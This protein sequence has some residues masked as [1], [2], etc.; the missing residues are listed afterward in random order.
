MILKRF[1]TDSLD[2]HPLWAGMSADLP[3]ERAAWIGLE[4]VDT[5]RPLFLRLKR[6]LE[7]PGGK[8]RFYLSADQRYQLWIN[9]KF[10]ALGPDRSDLNHWSVAGYELESEGEPLEL[11]LRLWWLP[12][13]L[14]PL[15]QCTHRPGFVLKG[16]GLLDA[17]LT[18]G[19]ADW[20][21]EDV[22][23]AVSCVKPDLCGFHVV[24]PSF[25]I[26]MTAWDCQSR[27][28]PMAVLRPPEE[29]ERYGAR[30]LGWRMHPSRLPEQRSERFQPCTVR[31]L[32]VPVRE[33]PWMLSD[34][35]DPSMAEVQAF[36]RGNSGAFV[37]PPER[38]IECL[39]DLET[40]VC[41]YPEL[42]VSGGLGAEVSLEW[43]E[44]LFE[45]VSGRAVQPETSKGQR[46]RVE[47]KV[48]HGFGDRWR[49]SG[50][51]NRDLPAFWWR[52]G[53]YLRLILR[54][55]SE[56]LRLEAFSVRRT[57]FPFRAEGEFSCDRPELND[58]WPL[59]VAGLEHCAHEQWVDC[60]YYEQLS[61]VGD[62]TAELSF[63]CLTRDDA[64]TRRS[65]E[66]FDWSRH[67]NGWVAQRY[68]SAIRQDSFTYS[69]LYP[70]LVRDYAYWRRDEGFVAALLP[71]IRAMMQECL[72][73]QGADGLVH[74][75]PGWAFV[76]W[77]PEWDRGCPPG[78]EAGDSSLVNLHVSRALEA[79]ADLEENGGERD[80]APWIRQKRQ[81]LNQ[82]ICA[83]Y[84]SERDQA[85]ADDG[86][87]QTFSE[88]AQVWGIL[89]GVLAPDQE[90][91]C[92]RTWLTKRLPMAPMS[93]Y[94]SHYGFEALYRLGESRA[95]LDR[96]QF[97]SGLKAQGL[98]TT[99]ERPEPSRSDCHGWGAHPLFHCFASLAG[100]R[101]ASP[102]FQ[103][104]RIAPLAGALR[105]IS[106]TLP[107]PEGTLRLTLQTENGEGSVQIFLPGDLSGE[108]LYGDQARKLTPGINA[109][110]VSIPDGFAPV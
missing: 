31:A 41:G 35:G 2:R 12:E 9:G 7:L 51:N 29:H 54:T 83:R 110:T 91:A 11:E 32:R 42:R 28:V 97:W 58:M 14:A 49:P 40:Y 56:P 94:F 36:L 30:P 59:L 16:E 45:A 71:G 64:L 82:R 108:W 33:A 73:W 104:V 62:N 93:I 18:T 4:K 77:V 87:H 52:S 86:H 95:F 76:D 90:Q 84:W 89:S 67:E 69:M 63:Y 103:T 3:I 21:A 46:D 48:F 74:S 34:P 70:G 23:K 102:G 79:W 55:A 88:H 5:A 50:E 99:P 107:H 65:L 22:S 85:L 75:V 19:K 98:R 66:L 43:A 80:L 38:E 26:D 25:D 105:D 1:Y 61:Y 17:L 100:I 10:C 15:A 44:S 39:I 96:L 57:G 72:A 92:L 53:R 6:R 60:P 8:H 27:A 78:A 101:P 109:F 24:G 13:G 81:Q 68:P 37:L 106:L 47:G 20:S